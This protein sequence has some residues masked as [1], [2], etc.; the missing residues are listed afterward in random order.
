MNEKSVHPINVDVE[1]LSQ[2]IDLDTKPNSENSDTCSPGC[3][4]GE[5]SLKAPIISKFGWGKKT[6]PFIIGLTISIL[7]FLVDKLAV[8]LFSPYLSIVLLSISY[9]I[10]S[11]RVILTV[12]KNLNLKTIFDENFLMFIATIGGILTNNFLEA[13]AVMLFYKLGQI[14]EESLEF[15]GI[16]TRIRE[17][18]LAWKLLRR[19]WLKRA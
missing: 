10:V 3:D 19:F 13:I 9:V 16:K 6:F 4:C 15:Y 14:V 2:N 18:P 11:Y 7:G 5:F 12:F 8:K 17:Y 1:E